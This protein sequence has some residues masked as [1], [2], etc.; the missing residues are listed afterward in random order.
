[1]SA[2]SWAST[3]QKDVVL[4][5]LNNAEAAAL[6][7]GPAAQTLL[8][9]DNGTVN[10][11]RQVSSADFPI[12]IPV[13]VP[14]DES[15]KQLYD[16]IFLDNLNAAT[17]RPDFPTAAQIISANWQRTFGITPDEVVSLD[18][19]AL[20]RLLEVTGPVSMPDGEQ[21]TSDNV[22][23]KLL[24]EAYFRYPEG[25]AE[26]D[27]YF[28]AAASA[29]FERV[30]SA[31][32][33]VWAMSQAVD[34]RGQPR[35][36]DDVERRPRNAGA[37]RRHPAAGRAAGDQRGRDRA[38]RVLPRPVVVEDRLL[39]PLRGHRH[40]ERL[41]ARRPDVHGRGAPA[42]RHP[43]QRRASRLRR[44]RTCTTSIA[45]RC[46]SMAPSVP[47]RPR[48]RY[49]SPDSRRRPGLRSPTSLG[50]PRSSPSTCGTG[51]RHSCAP[52]SPVR[53]EVRTYRGPHDA[54][55]QC[56][57]GD[58]QPT[59][60]AD[61]PPEDDRASARRAGRVRDHVGDARHPRWDAELHQL[62]HGA[63]EDAHAADQPT[64]CQRGAADSR[65]TVMAPLR[66][67]QPIG[68]DGPLT[69]LRGG[70]RDDVQPNGRRLL[71]S[72]PTSTA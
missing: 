28:A 9:V 27:A 16:S 11:V 15:A 47:R 56:D 29:V 71:R 22:V 43:E 21:L 53:Q 59:R 1:M 6:G 31:D 26:S 57:E 69:R 14:V 30:M 66:G 68:H 60:R 19:I 12:A 23:S 35:H 33:D 7:G 48:S 39:P 5:F 8:S 34:R 58:A 37:L 52:R 65:S 62:D 17:S 24:N 44:Q 25:G 41:H 42:I 10:V 72:T 3:V 20:S 36:A 51:R 54:H 49:R 55:D 63:H 45:P 40:D 2:R 50:P 32:Y 61:A 70:S 64:S 13:D 38:G 4:A 18:P 46:S 67:L